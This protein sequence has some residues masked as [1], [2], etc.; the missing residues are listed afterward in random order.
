MKMLSVSHLNLRVHYLMY[1]I[2]GLC[3]SEYFTKSSLVSR[4]HFNI[5]ITYMYTLTLDL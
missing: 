2:I 4:I 1:Y 3:V 5:F